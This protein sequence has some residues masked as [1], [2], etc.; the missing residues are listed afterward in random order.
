MK[1]L[2]KEIERAFEE[3]GDTSELNAVDI[4][5]IAK[6]FNPTGAG[7]WYAVDYDKENGV[8]FGF[9]DLLERELGYFSLY[10][11]ESFKDQSFG[12]SIERDEWFPIGE[13]T[14][15]QVMD[16]EVS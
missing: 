8:F 2:T 11:L 4:K 15:Q 14:L 13:Y 3:Q 6:F 5:V 12:L 7:T 10:E 9:V 16:D 1:L